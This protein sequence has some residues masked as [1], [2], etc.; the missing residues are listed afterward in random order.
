MITEE[1]V[2]VELLLLDDEADFDS[3]LLLDI[4]DASPEIR[5]TVCKKIIARV[6]ERG[7]RRHTLIDLLRMS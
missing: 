5:E 6:R 2:K 7:V 4:K 3:K 1:Q